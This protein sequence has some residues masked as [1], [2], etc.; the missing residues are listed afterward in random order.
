LKVSDEFTVP[1]CASHHRENHTTGDE[2]R[3]WQD[4]GLDPLAIAGDLWRQSREGDDPEQRQLLDQQN[5]DGATPV[6]SPEQKAAASAR[7]QN[8]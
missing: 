4:R 2:R 7:E 8:P 1:L 6:R 5:A 3:W